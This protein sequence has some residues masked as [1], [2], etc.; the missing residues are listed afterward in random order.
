[1]TTGSFETPRAAPR[2]GWALLWTGAAL[3]VLG[4]VIGVAAMLLDAFAAFRR[5][6]ASQAPRTDAIVESVG[7]AQIAALSGVT[8]AVLGAILLIVALVRL[9]RSAAPRAPIG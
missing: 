7:F 2:R 9:S 4:P 8:A 5:V 6:E 3:L 1:V